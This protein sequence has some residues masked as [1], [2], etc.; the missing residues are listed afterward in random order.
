EYVSP[1]AYRQLRVSASF[2]NPKPVTFS[3]LITAPAEIARLA[4]LLDSLHAAG[5]ET[6]SCPAIDA[7]YRLTFQDSVAGQPVVQASMTVCL[8]VSV[9]VGGKLQPALWNS[10]PVIA[11]VRHLLAIPAHYR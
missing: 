6:M 4:T 5:Q 1:T 11:R 3:K 10:A 9:T 2:M 8:T 7:T